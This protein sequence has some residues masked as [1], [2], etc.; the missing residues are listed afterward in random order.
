KDSKPAETREPELLTIDRVIHPPYPDDSAPELAQ[1]AKSP[2]GRTRLVFK[3]ALKYDYDPKSVKIHGNVVEGSHGESYKQT[4][5]SGNAA[6][7]HQAFNL[8]RKPLTF[9]PMA[10]FPGARPA[11]ELTV[12]QERWSYVDTLARDNAGRTVFSL[13]IDDTSTAQVIF[14]NGKAGG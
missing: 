5:G 11:I 14:G 7:E 10:S 12:A 3:E 2:E 8:T 9:L 4:L 1:S 13:W 6:R